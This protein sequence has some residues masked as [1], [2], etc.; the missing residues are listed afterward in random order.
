MSGERL[1]RFFSRNPISFALSCWVLRLG[2]VLAAV[3]VGRGKETR[4]LGR[5]DAVSMEIKDVQGEAG[6]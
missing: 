4:L 2:D 3:R 1:R 6:R 5:K